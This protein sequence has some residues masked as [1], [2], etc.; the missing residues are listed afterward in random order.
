MFNGKILNNTFNNNSNFTSIPSERRRNISPKTIADKYI[1]NI[2]YSKNPIYPNY[3]NPINYLNNS[4]PQYPYYFTDYNALNNYNIN[5]SQQNFYYGEN[6]SNYNRYLYPDE[7]FLNNYNIINNKKAINIRLIK[8]PKPIMRNVVNEKMRK[9]KKNNYVKLDIINCETQSPIMTCLNA[10]PYS[11]LRRKSFIQKYNKINNYIINSSSKNHDEILE[12]INEEKINSIQKG[13]LYNTRLKNIDKYKSF[14]NS[15]YNFRQKENFRNIKSIKNNIKKC[16]NSNHLNNNGKNNNKIIKSIYTNDFEKKENLVKLIRQF[17]N[18][19]EHYIIS[20]FNILFNYFIAQ[21]KFFIEDKI[22]KNKILLLKRFQRAKIH[23]TEKKG[24]YNYYLEQKEALEKSNNNITN[25]YKSK[26]E[27]KYIKPIKKKLHNFNTITSKNN[28]QK[29]KLLFI[30]TDYTFKSN[31]ALFNK[32]IIQNENLPIDKFGKRSTNFYNKNRS[33][34]NLI[35]KKNL[36]P[37]IPTYVKTKFILRTTINNNSNKKRLI[38]TKKRTDKFNKNKKY[39]ID[40]TLNNNLNLNNSYSN[41]NKFSFKN[42]NCIRSPLKYKANERYEYEY[43][44]KED[45]EYE[46][47]IEEVIIKDICTYDKKFSVFIKY[48]TSQTFE[49]NYLRF[50]LVKLQNL[51]LNNIDEYIECTHNDSIFLPSIYSKSKMI[52]NEISEEKESLNISNIQ[53]DEKYIN[54]LFNMIVLL[55]HYNRRWLIYYYQLFFNVLNTTVDYS[56]K[57]Y[58]KGINKINEEIIKSK[59]Y[60]D[61]KDKNI[62]Y[63]NNFEMD[64]KLTNVELLNNIIKRSNSVKKIN[65]KNN[66]I[67]LFDSEDKGQLSKRNR[68]FSN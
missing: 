22:N 56:R 64:K 24:R 12:S 27:F 54:K 38:Y 48:V 13:S 58:K 61:W 33:Q 18:L 19:I 14:N 42:M 36:S 16:N 17:I 29:N 7:N 10:D 43:N 34:N 52:M 60:L 50:K 28:L 67:N 5:N 46:D 39:I 51:Y 53:G 25:L 8:Q 23:K 59:T 66:M 1:T 41:Y 21:M 49:Q 63:K 40:D 3:I 68:R 45:N 37:N 32:T 20:S 62:L 31:K 2:I 65:Q 15:C 4:N 26:K 55:E 11:K 30:N 57:S 35:P 44:Y 9:K 47:S 6:Y